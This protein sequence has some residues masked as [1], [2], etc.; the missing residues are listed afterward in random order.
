MKRLLFISVILLNISAVLGAEA[1]D[2]VRHSSVVGAD[3][4]NIL[5]RLS[6]RITKLEEEN[7]KL[8]GKIEELE[9]QIE[10]IQNSG[11]LP[12]TSNTTPS[13]EKYVI[14]PGDDE[15]AA[16]VVKVPESE[17]A[18]NASAEAPLE[19]EQVIEVTKP[20]TLTI[21]EVTEDG[22]AF[23]S[24]FALIGKGE[25]AEAQKGFEQF[26]E[27]YPESDYVA[28]AHFWVGEIYFKNDEMRK[29]ALNYGRSYKAKPRGGTR[30]GESL[31]KLAESLDKL[32]QNREACLNYKRFE[33]E[34]T[35][36]H[37]SLIEKAQDAIQRLGC[38]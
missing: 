34:F 25:L 4:S 6:A 27:A 9:Y 33:K 16:Y 21:S 15:G 5:G 29:A 23:E 7:R 12:R 36:A 24:V 32:S 18:E 13:G 35:N 1:N 28:N 20:G 38:E 10:R 2:Q 30:S 26:V 11:A 19:Q 8:N 37:S 31:L 3:Y 17:D 14:R 22:K